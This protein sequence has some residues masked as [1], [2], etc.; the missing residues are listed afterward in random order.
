MASNAMQLT[1]LSDIARKVLDL[2][3]R[4][5]ITDGSSLISHMGVSRRDEIAKSVRELES[6]D[7][8]E[9][10]GPVNSDELPFARFGVRPSAKDY[11]QRMLKQL[12]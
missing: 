1:D 6:L 3:V 10:G 2:I 9:V 11:L 12:K 5:N 8:I 4:H 7:L